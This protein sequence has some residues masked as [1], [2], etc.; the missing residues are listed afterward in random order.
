MQS[1]SRDWRLYWQDVI[2]SCRKIERYIAG[3]DRTAFEADERTYDAVLRNLE[4]I[5]EAVKQLPDEARALATDVE[6]RK[7]AGTRDFI[8]HAYFGIDGD[9]LWD[10][11]SNKIPDLRR[12][13]EAV[14]M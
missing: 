14:P 7:I 2:A 6:W 3:M 13:L 4:L 9:I 5:G 12:A 1:V 11:V 8:A 10:V